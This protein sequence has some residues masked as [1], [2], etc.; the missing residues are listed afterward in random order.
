MKKLACFLPIVAGLFLVLGCV[1]AAIDAVNY[2]PVTDRPEIKAILVSEEVFAEYGTGDYRVTIGIF[3]YNKVLAVSLEIRNLTAVDLSPKEYSVTLADG[4]D[5]KPIKLLSRQDL[6]ATKA[7]VSGASTGAFQ[8]QLIQATV[9]TVMNT[10]NQ[11]TKDKLIEIIDQGIAQYFT[12]RPV[13][14]NDQ[15]SGVLCFV[16]DFRLEYPLTV[17]VRIKGEPYIVKFLPRRKDLV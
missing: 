2:N 11:P 1:P 9:D 7:K 13:Y 15:R 6:I 16:P 12:F 5:L 17:T 14:A 8:D 3:E 4:R 10:M